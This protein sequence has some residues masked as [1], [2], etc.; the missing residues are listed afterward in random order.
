MGFDYDVFFSYR[1]RPLDGEITQKS[2][3][4][5]E[6]YKL[7]RGIRIQGFEDIRR[8][9]RDTEEL[10]V[11]RILTDT[12]DNALHSCNCLV[13]VCSTDTPSSEWIDREV[14]IFIEIGR[15]ERIYPLLISGDPEHS[16]PPSLKLV[17][18]IAD[19]IMDIRTEGNDVKKMMAKADTELLKVIAGIT[20]CEHADL[21]R[22]H[23][24]R[25][26]RRIAT[27]AGGAAAV[28][29]AVTGISLGLMRM[30]G[31]YRDEAARREQASMRI[32]SELTYSLPDHLSNV[33]GAY[34]KIADILRGNTEDINAILSLSSNKEAAEFE[35]AANYA[36]LATAGIVLGQYEDAL[37]YEDKAIEIYRVLADSGYPGG[38]EALASAYNNRGKTANAAGRYQEAEADYRK[39]A[40]LLE[41]IADPDPI[42]AVMTA[43]N[44]GANYSDLGDNVSASDQYEQALALL[45]GIEHNEEAVEASARINYN[46]G[47]LLCRTGN[48]EEAERRLQDACMSYSELR[49]YTDSMQNR[50]SHVQ[51]V[52]VLAT[53]L[54]DEGR[55]KEADYYF[56]EAIKTAEELAKNNDDDTGALITLANLYNNRGLCFNRQ[57]DYEEADKYY[58][59]A[60][61]LYQIISDR[62]GTASDAAIYAQ[63][64]LN[65]GENAFKMGNYDRTWDRFEEGLIIY[66]EA[67]QSLGIFDNA[68]YYA[69]LSYYE[70]ICVQDFQGAFD[71]AYAA[72]QLQP[73]QPLV[74]MNLAYACLYCGYYDDADTL[75]RHI[76]SLGEGQVETI[77]GDF[78]AQQQAGLYSPHTD[79]VI[80]EILGR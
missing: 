15:A 30:A 77:I 34:V 10:P 21:L 69:W 65:I 5:L 73:D 74:Q 42:L 16:F 13:V 31:N 3:N 14:S 72:Y 70:L 22:E 46:Y 56:E 28:L 59:T 80:R 78:E 60:A 24:L 48:Y 11:S 45:E 43:M 18:D 36:K 71:A 37:S 20:G 4:A 47:V 29:L 39:A 64:L 27:R 79:Y 12:I 9:F 52:S 58:Q 54:S 68:L 38:L 32:L 57:G 67:C 7:P 53:C 35:A 19:R 2:F 26:S 23:Q 61:N 76:A 1:H 55:F 17:P 51:A 62:T 33:P 49:E 6:S 40:E 50:S 66:R 41:T 25:R 75:F 63:F 8:A 44:A